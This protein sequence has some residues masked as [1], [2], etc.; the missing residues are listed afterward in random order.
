MRSLEPSGSEQSG[1]SASTSDPEVR[2]SPLVCVVVL[3][4][5][6]FRLVLAFALGFAL[7][8]GVADEDDG[9]E[10]ETRA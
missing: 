7:F 2:S 8:F 5:D 1:T 3:R 6:P 9:T 4:V 10:V